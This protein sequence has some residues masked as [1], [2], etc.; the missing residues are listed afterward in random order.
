MQH[1]E[2]PASL[3]IATFDTISTAVSEIATADKLQMDGGS[4]S[5]SGRLQ[6][7]NR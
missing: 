1:K 5:G 2:Q 7:D 4:K 6:S 3:L